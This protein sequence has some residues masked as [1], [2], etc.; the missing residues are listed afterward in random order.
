MVAG[1][2]SGRGVSFIDKLLTKCWQP[3]QSDVRCR[4][5]RRGLRAYGFVGL[6]LGEGLRSDTFQME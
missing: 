6:G 1:D 3:S 4:K 2:C 5:S